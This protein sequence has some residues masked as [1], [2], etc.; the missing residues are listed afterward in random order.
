MLEDFGDEIQIGNTLVAGGSWCILSL[1]LEMTSRVTRVTPTR[2][3]C[4][5][6]E[7]SLSFSYH[8][9]L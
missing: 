2:D 7:L 1:V 9:V 8:K 5:Q 4:V 3:R 6:F